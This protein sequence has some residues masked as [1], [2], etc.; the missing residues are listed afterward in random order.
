MLEDRDECEQ[1]RRT[2]TPWQFDCVWSH[3]ADGETLVMI[4]NRIGVTRQRVEEIADKTRRV[5]VGGSGRV[6]TY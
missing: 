1:L 5:L 2:L 6:P 3:Y 4:G